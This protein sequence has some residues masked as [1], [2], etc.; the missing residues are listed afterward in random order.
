MAQYSGWFNYPAPAGGDDATYSAE[1]YGEIQRYLI[2]F[3]AND[4]N[5]GPVKNLTTYDLQVTEAAPPAL[6]VVVHPGVA[7]NHGF[8]YVSDADETVAIPANMSGNLRIDRIVLRYGFADGRIRIHHLQGVPAGAP[9]P[10]ALVQGAVSWDIP[11]AQIAVADGAG[12]I[13]DANISDER[14]YANLPMGCYAELA[15]NSGGDVE[16]NAVVILGPAAE[17]FDTTNVQ[18]DPDVIGVLAERLANGAKGKVCRCGIARMICTAAAVAVGDYLQHSAAAGQAERVTGTGTSFAIAL[19]AKGAG[20]G[21]VEALLFAA[22]PGAGQF[23]LRNNGGDYTTN[24]GVFVDVDAAN[25][26][27]VLTTHGNPARVWFGG[28]VDTDGAG[29]PA[30]IYFTAEVDGGNVGGTDGLCQEVSEGTVREVIGHTSFDVEL[31]LAAGA[32][33]IDLQWRMSRSDGWLRSSNAS[34]VAFGA[35]EL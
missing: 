10:P 14:Y 20:V 25:L 15:N 22:H 19:T 5:R 34:F 23:I 3:D 7:L 24:S 9:V 11:L 4:A 6:S 33:T 32:H 16:A 13:I 1:E 27:I 31:P 17:S 29:T 8:W 18:G 30:I 26:R 28:D 21:T 12:N 2:G 35:R